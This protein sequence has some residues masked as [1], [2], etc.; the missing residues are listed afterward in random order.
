VIED[1]EYVLTK[2][3]F[4][5][6]RPNT[7]LNDECINAYVSLINR[8]EKERGTGVN[9]FAFNTFFFT[10]LERM[11]QDGTYNLR[12]FMRIVEKK[13]VKLRAVK[14]ILMPINIQHYH[15][16]LLDCNLE[17]NSFYL[18][19]SMGTS[20]EQAAYFVDVAKHFLQDYFHATKGE[21]PMSAR[22]SLD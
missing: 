13:K 14:N 2:E 4:N 10:M 20:R 3:S 16:L 1:E 15:W 12:K 5:R 22:K 9:T 6:F 18:V 21:V 17:T 8:R 19:D 11:Q 7:W